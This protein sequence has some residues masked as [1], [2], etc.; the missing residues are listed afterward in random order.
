M[1]E[2]RAVVLGLLV[3]VLVALAVAYWRRP[4]A[5]FQHIGGYRV[6]VREKEGDSTRVVRF[7]VPTRLLSGIA[8]LSPIERFGGRFDTDWDGHDLTA[9]E[10]LEAADQSSPG[11]PG[12][13][14]KEDTRIEVT[15]EGSVLLISVQDDWDRTV[16]VKVPRSLVEAFSG[17]FDLS[18]REMLRHL[19]ELGPGEVITVSDGDDEV[20]F[21]AEPR[22]GAA[23]R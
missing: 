11:K 7:T 4:T 8:R 18:P 23:K 1:K 17:D 2:I 21:T 20:I 3:V 12:V 16:R 15:K 22:R 10:I 9:R 5:E 14:E 13:I 19:D 6:E